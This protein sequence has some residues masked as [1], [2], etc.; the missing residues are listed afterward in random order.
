MCG[1][2]SSAS[3][4][5]HQMLQ[6]R[7][8]AGGL[9]EPELPVGRREDIQQPAIRQE[10]I[11]NDSARCLAGTPIGRSSCPAAIRCAATAF[12]TSTSASVWGPS[13]GARCLVTRDGISTPPGQRPPLTRSAPSDMHH[14]ATLHDPPLVR[15]SP[16]LAIEKHLARTTF[17]E[18]SPKT[19]PKSGPALEAQFPQ[20]LSGRFPQISVTSHDSARRT[21][22][23][24]RRWRDADD[25]IQAD[26]R[27]V[28]ALTGFN[29]ADK[30]I[31]RPPYSDAN[32]SASVAS[33]VGGGQR[34][35]KHGAISG[36][37]KGVLFL[38]EAGEFFLRRRL[39]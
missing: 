33:I 10:V 34:M 11:S 15:N 27:T 23:S 22:A 4:P 1:R 31:T 8:S 32:H 13:R 9:I 7:I 6:H 2:P 36:A 14:E 20:L 3:L 18:A 17:I 28:H 26:W 30:L 25:G 24:G 29:L 37:H 16:T 12:N 38:D 19:W 21:Q 39:Y 5:G 35:A